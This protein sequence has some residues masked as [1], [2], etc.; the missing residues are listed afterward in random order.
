MKDLCV[1]GLKKHFLL[2]VA[3]QLLRGEVPLVDVAF[4]IDCKASNRH[5]L[6]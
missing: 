4:K 6:E 5:M 1:E 2:R 3:I